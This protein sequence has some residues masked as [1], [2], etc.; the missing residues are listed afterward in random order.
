M[1]IVTL[2][3]ARK[4]ASKTVN[5]YDTYANLPLTGRV[6]SLYITTDTGHIYY[7]NSESQTY[8]EITQSTREDVYLDED[9]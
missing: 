4:Y 8:I 5:Q 7:W 2:A 3:L 1:D 6:G 9:L